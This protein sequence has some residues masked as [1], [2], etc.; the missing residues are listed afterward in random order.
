M[1]TTIRQYPSLTYFLLTFI[2]SWIGIII[3]SIFMG[4]PTT[5]TQ[6]NNIGP[7]ALIPFL[8]GPAIVSLLLTGILYG[9]DGFRELKS[10]MFKW[11]INVLWYIFSMFT[12]PALLVI[13]LLILFRFS[14]DFIPKILTETNKLNFVITGILTGILGGGLFEE[15]GWT[16]FVT[17]ELRKKYGIVKTGLLL[18]FFW[19]LWHL[20]PVYWGSGDVNGRINWLLFLPGLFSHYAILIPFRVLLVWLHDRV[21]SIIPVIL[22]HASLTA[23]LLFILNIPASGLPLFIYYLCLATVLWIIVGIIILKYNNLQKPKVTT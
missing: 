16:G 4:M 10:R 14:N 12:I 18:G 11:K 6:F 17:P 20:L 7:V 21:Q 9:K 5:S 2:I 23:F 1:K 8:L 19:G 22:M 3:I 13:I 15:I